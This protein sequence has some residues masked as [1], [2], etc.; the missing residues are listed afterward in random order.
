VSASNPVPWGKFSQD[1][2][3]AE[4]AHLRASDQDRDVVLQVLGDAY[5]DGR[6]TREEYDT[7]AESAGSAKTL[8]DLPPII[9]DLVPEPPAR[10]TSELA[11]ATPEQLQARA[12]ERYRS[13]R[14]QAV[15]G[16]VIPSVITIVIWLV[17]TAPGGFPWPVFVVLGTG[18]NLLR[19]LLNKQ[20]L[21]DEERRKLERQQMKELGPPGHGGD[22]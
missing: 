16:M 12:E 5:A 8:G 15:S 17:T 22:E 1:P 21:V 18:V 6:L 9:R 10:R 3:R 4:A 14:R 19:V 2:R 13:A 20:D 11:L 7:R